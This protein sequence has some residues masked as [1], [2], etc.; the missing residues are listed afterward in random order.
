MS[1]YR[2]EALT[3]AKASNGLKATL[4]EYEFTVECQ[5]KELG[6]LCVEQKR[7]KEELTQALTEKEELLLRWMEEKREEADRLNNYNDI[8]ER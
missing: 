3:L 5:S 6:A 7:L 8:Q 2:Q 1:K 4:A